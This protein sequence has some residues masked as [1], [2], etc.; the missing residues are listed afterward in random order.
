MV[1]WGYQVAEESREVCAGE[2]DGWEVQVAS[3]SLLNW[4]EDEE[5]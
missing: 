1:S 3:L 4:G 2:G 5:A